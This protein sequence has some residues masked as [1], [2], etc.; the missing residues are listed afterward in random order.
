MI[1]AFVTRAI[2]VNDRGKKI[3]VWVVDEVDQNQ[4]IIRSTEY[5]TKEQA[6]KKACKINKEEY[7]EGMY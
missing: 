1:E 2:G 7:E 3:P 4:Q 5:T 6:W